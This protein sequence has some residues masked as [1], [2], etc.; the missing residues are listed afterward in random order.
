MSRKTNLTKD[1][2]LSDEEEP[3]K[4]NIEK[5]IRTRITK[6]EL[7]KKERKE[8]LDKLNNILGITDANKKICFDDL[9]DK[10][11]DDIDDLIN[12]VKQY[13]T[14]SRFPYFCKEVD[15]KHISIVKSIYKHEGFNVLSY[16]NKTTGKSHYTVEK[17]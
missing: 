4:I 13:F 3:K 16:R 11:R 1:L 8:V 17:K 14:C 2:K 9:T 6:K 10:V 15:D 7:Y 12:D 5:K